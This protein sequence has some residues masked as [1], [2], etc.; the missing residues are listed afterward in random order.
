MFLTLESA[1]VKVETR[2]YRL[3]KT[4]VRNALGGTNYNLFTLKEKEVGSVDIVTLHSQCNNVGAGGDSRL[5]LPPVFFVV[6][7]KLVAV[8]GFYP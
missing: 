1:G 2:G 3:H 4:D 5:L 7:S 8:V 6:P